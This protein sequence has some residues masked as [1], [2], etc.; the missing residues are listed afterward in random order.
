MFV[1]ELSE[2]YSVGCGDIVVL[3]KRKGTIAITLSALMLAGCGATGG[4][5]YATPGEI[6]EQLHDEGIPH[7]LEVDEYGTFNPSITF[8]GDD[9]MHFL[10]VEQHD[11][12]APDEVI[13]TLEDGESVARGD[14]WLIQFDDTISGGAMHEVAGALG[15]EITVG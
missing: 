15:G 5:S 14:D 6:S 8:D 10:W 7:T 4:S 13:D 3:M 9:G 11:G 1:G 12:W 2:G